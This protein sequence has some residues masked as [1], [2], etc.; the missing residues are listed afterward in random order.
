MH[1]PEATTTMMYDVSRFQTLFVVEDANKKAEDEDEDGL[2]Q[3]EE[4]E[5]LI[6]HVS[7]EMYDEELALERE[8]QEFEERNLGNLEWPKALQSFAC[9]RCPESFSSRK[10]LAAHRRQLHHGQTSARKPPT[11]LTCEICGKL[12]HRNNALMNHM[13]SHTDQRNYPCPQCPARFVQSCNRDRHVRDTHLKE[14]LYPCTEVG[15]HRRYQQRR[16]RDQHVKTVHRQERDLVCS[17]CQATF[18]HPVNYKKH[19]ASH[20]SVKSFSCHI[21]KKLFGRQENRDVH[22]FVHSLCKAYVCCVCGADYMRRQQLIRH[23]AASG[24]VNEKIV[25]QKPQFSAA[26]SQ[27]SKGKEVQTEGEKVD[28]LGNGSFPGEEDLKELKE[29]EEELLEEFI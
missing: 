1:P 13:N 7:Q 12:F 6:C 16:E 29:E 24:H 19:L 18:S 15:C 23:S 9:L 10:E 3:E 11:V 2:D 22:L 17:Q 28:L 8:E 27:K 25:R 5:D 14:Y 21:C 4:M 20:N 26:F